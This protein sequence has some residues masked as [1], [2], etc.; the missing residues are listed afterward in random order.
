MTIKTD[1]KM[2]EILIKEAKALPR[3]LS[4]S[5]KDEA[6]K[7]LSEYDRLVEAAM[8]LIWYN[9]VINKEN[10]QDLKDSGPLGYNV[11]IEL[12]LYMLY[13]SREIIVE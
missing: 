3:D 5:S 7:T 13:R 11:G 4:A 12:L 1:F 8:R 2:L 6:L 9:K 10:W